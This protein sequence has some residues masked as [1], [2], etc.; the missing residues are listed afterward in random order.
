VNN[1]VQL[2][3]KSYTVIVLP[4]PINGT[5][6]KMLLFMKWK[7]RPGIKAI[8]KVELLCLNGSNGIGMVAA[9]MDLSNK[10]MGLL[11]IDR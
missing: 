6:D 9:C 7:I 8:G 3:I 10:M 4:L 11:F 2:L 1:L 5:L